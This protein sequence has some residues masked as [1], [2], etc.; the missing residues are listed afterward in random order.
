MPFD[1]S[2]EILNIAVTSPA[3]NT[4]EALS[5]AME[6]PPLPSSL[7]FP[8]REPLDGVAGLCCDLSQTRELL[9][10]LK[11]RRW[12]R[13]QTMCMLAAQKASLPE[14]LN[15]REA[16]TGVYVGTGMGSL[17]ETAI[18]LENMIRQKESFPKPAHFVNSVHN[19]VGST[20]GL[21]FGLKGENITVAHREISFDAALGH[22]LSALRQGRMK[23]AVVCGADE[24]NYFHVLAG[25]ALGLWKT[26]KQSF[27]PLATGNSRGTF[28]GEGASV[29]VLSTEKKTG[30]SSF[31]NVLG[32][33]C[34]RYKRDSRTYIK[35]SHAGDF[36]EEL[37]SDA[38]VQ[39]SE[40]DL[41]LSGANG[42]GRLDAVYLGVGAELER[43]SGKKIPQAAFKHLCGDYRAASGFGFAVA[44]LCLRL[45]RVPGGLWGQETHLPDG[46]V[47]TILLYQLSRS[48]VHSA[49][50]LRSL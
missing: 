22:A 25:S 20:L 13:L 3:G 10:P 12:G 33:K 30:Q 15:G 14:I 23:Y 18:F 1:I 41:I 36:L 35:L 46:S 8:G 40:V 32:A 11:I 42:D 27:K 31:G 44:A 48:G 9:N 47:K 7:S 2:V 21:E 49:C 17:G 5:S 39:T 24:M 29:C 19:A 43:R 37:L 4:L 16:Q 50:L 26:K 28:P 45:G 6:Y 34:A 38:G